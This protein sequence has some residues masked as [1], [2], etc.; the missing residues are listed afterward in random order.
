MAGERTPIQQEVIDLI[1]FYEERGWNW[2][3]A[4]EFILAQHSGRLEYVIRP[5]IRRNPRSCNGRGRRVADM[6]KRAI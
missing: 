2:E 1:A 3:D 5:G 6:P 4:A